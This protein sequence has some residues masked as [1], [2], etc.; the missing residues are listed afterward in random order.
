MRGIITQHS[1]NKTKFLFNF[2][3]DTSFQNILVSD[4]KILSFIEGKT[5]DFIHID[6]DF[7]DYLYSKMN[8]LDPVAQAT[9][10]I[11]TIYNQD[12][13]LI[14]F[15]ASYF[16]YIDLFKHHNIEINKKVIIIIG[17]S[18]HAKTLKYL[19]SQKTSNVIMVSS[20][21]ELGEFNFNQ[22]KLFPKIDIL[23][24]TLDT[25]EYLPIIN[26]FKIAA[27][28]DIVIDLACNSGRSDLLI[29]AK[30]L[31]CKT[32]NAQRATVYTAA[33]AYKIINS[34]LENFRIDNAYS[35]LQN[36]TN[37]VLIGMDNTIKSQVANILGQHY[38]KEIIDTKILVETNEKLN[39]LD[40][41]ENY[42]LDYYYNLESLVI[43]K[44]S[45]QNNKIIITSDGVVDNYNN[46]KILQ[47][48]SRIYYLNTPTENFNKQISKLY[49]KRKHVF[50][51]CTDITVNC[52]NNTTLDITN[53]IIKEYEYY[54]YK[55]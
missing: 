13:F 29:Q 41:I 50:V 40:I 25:K 22:F 28:P 20:E 38:Q 17:N 5:F 39:Y 54:C 15:N 45:E 8:Y 52:Y 12:N 51:D 11:D 26:L 37:I 47:K 35:Q 24:N 42:G 23:I 16:G 31:K 14:G 1:D 48:H 44:L 7:Q 36:Q 18:N 34:D 43:E 55:K 49:L 33:Y 19:L 53:A 6:H 3:G 2:W 27:K 32:Y 30:Q 9:N 21:P 10:T 4:E 46:I